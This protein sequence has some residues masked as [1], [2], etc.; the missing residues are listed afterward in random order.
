MYKVKFGGKNGQTVNL[1]ESPD[2]VAIRTKGKQKLENVALSPESR[3]L[4]NETTEVA[5]FPEAGVTVRRVQPEPVEE[6]TSSRGAGLSRRDVTR[7]ALKQEENIRFA[8]RVLEDAQ[9]GEVTLYT[10]NFFVKF[11]DNV[12]EADC[13]NTL[14]QYHLAIKSTLAFAQNA[15]FVQAEE[16]TGLEVFR[17][18]ETMLRE[19]QVEYC[20][21]ELVQERRFKAINPL[22]WHLARTTIG[23]QL[24]DAGINIEEAWRHTRGEGMTIAIIDDGIDT[25][26]P[27]FAGRIIHPF[28]A[29]D[30]TDDPR[31][32][33]PKENHGTAC[34]GMACAI[35][36]P[37]GASGTAPGALLMPMR[38]AN[39]IGSVVEAMAFTWAAD[40]G[41]DVISCSWGPPD[42]HWWDTVDP[43]HKSQYAIPDHTRLALEYALTKGRGGKGCVVLFAA[44]NGNEDIGNDGYASHPGVIAVAA[45]NDTGSRCVYSD[46]GE[47]VWVSFPS[48]DYED[49]GHPVPLTKGLRTTDRVGEAG[50]ISTGNY[51]DSFDGTSGA[52]PG[53]AGVVALVLAINPM[54]TATGVKHILRHACTRLDEK[55]GKYD[56]DGHSP[57]YGYGRIDAGKAVEIARLSLGAPWILEGFVRFSTLGNMVLPPDLWLSSGQPAKKVLGLRLKVN[58]GVQGL[59]VH[60]KVN[61]A[62][63]GIFENKK[64]DE[65]VG[66]TNGRKRVLGFAVKLDGPAAKDYA[67][68][69]SARLKGE[70]TPASAQDGAFCGSEGEDGK[71]VEAV[72]V[73]VRR[74]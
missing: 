5:S 31:P 71:A 29:T 38:L 65:Y 45:C 60:Y 54:L 21:P 30:N 16:G 12:P 67:V 20:H 52:C 28:N 47:A 26:H 34:A 48:G 22:Q 10:E 59:R 72:R 37:G 50:Y 57:Y 1:V 36:L 40:H 73:A 66:T 7:A 18:A 24:I 25:D 64:E 17:I 23:G 43:M 68:E 4:V 11:K 46:Y 49:T 70:E 39:G 53:M 58:P 9:S 14:A 63:E 32:K 74:K 69:Y 61:V 6:S 27:E 35:G 8:G 33:T 3:E 56:A 41:A 51:Y 62:G 19:P 2:L 15:Y 42:G 55:H 44:G 13:L